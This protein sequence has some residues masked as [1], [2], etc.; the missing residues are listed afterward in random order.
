MRRR[1]TSGGR[2]E[3]AIALGLGAAILGG[4]GSAPPPP[5]PPVAAPVEVVERRHAGPTFE[6]EIGALDEGKVKAAFQQAAKPLGACF[7]K[8]A[9]RV[10]FLAGEVRF[11]LRIARS[12]S[13]RWVFVKDSTLGGRGKFTLTNAVATIP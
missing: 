4:C 5:P 13:V 11:T 10:P 8:G 12:G 2:G 9:E 6:S 7:D 1:D 3:G